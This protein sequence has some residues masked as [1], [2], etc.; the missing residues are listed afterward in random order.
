AARQRNLL[1]PLGI[2]DLGVSQLIVLFST[3]AGLALAWMLWLVARGE[4]ERDPVLRAWRRVGGR[5]ARLGLAP[6]PHEP[7]GAWT[8]RVLAAQPRAAE[9]LA[10]LSARFIEWRY[11]GSTADPASARALAR[12]LLAHRPGRRAPL[13]DPTGNAFPD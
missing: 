1:T 3:L 11:A 8:R 12:D 2:R 5:Y 9:G 13:E 10:P 4:R 6:E 7:A